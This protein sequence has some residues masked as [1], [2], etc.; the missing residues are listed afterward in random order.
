MADVMIFAMAIASAVA[1]LIV[2]P[3]EA[4]RKALRAFRAYGKTEALPT[5]GR[6][7][8]LV[9]PATRLVESAVIAKPCPTKAG[10]DF[11]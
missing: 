5:D 6:G 4:H 7:E 9:T 10:F 11:K 8:D 2:R 1:L 3:S